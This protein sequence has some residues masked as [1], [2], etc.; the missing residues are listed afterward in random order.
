MT[1]GYLVDSGTQ[2]RNRERGHLSHG[3]KENVLLKSDQKKFVGVTRT[4]SANQKEKGHEE[5]GALWTGIQRYQ[6]SASNP[7]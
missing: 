5:K 7:A 6:Q 3:Q 1:N 2:S 4:V